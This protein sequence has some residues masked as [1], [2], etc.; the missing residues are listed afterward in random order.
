M[1]AKI[2]FSSTYGF[3]HN[4]TLVITSSKGTKSFYLGQDVKF[5]SRVLGMDSSYIVEQIG[6]RNIQ[7]PAV[8]NR[9]AKFI[10]KS[11]GLNSKTLNNLQPWELSAQ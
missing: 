7:D 6:S 4:W 11:L 2:E 9:L 1:K 5:C 10:I 8:N 3:D